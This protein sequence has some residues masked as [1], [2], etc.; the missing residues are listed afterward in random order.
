M[1]CRPS[2]SAD[3]NDGV[4]EQT[5]FELEPGAEWL[6]GLEAEENIAVR[7]S[8]LPDR[9]LTK[10]LEPTAWWLNTESSSRMDILEALNTKY[11]SDN[12]IRD[13]FNLR[14]SSHPYTLPCKAHPGDADHRYQIHPRKPFR[15]R[16][17]NADCFHKL[18]RAAL[19]H[20]IA[21]L[22]QEGIID[23]TALGL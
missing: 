6:F 17:A 19:V 8:L 3:Q 21:E 23:K 18:Q 12:E 9:T 13:L 20:W 5:F 14:G 22:A 16:C 11:Q 7:V 15:V 2:M 4:A 1:Y 10:S